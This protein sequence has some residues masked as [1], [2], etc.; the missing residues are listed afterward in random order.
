M[1]R[2]LIGR[3]RLPQSQAGIG[4]LLG[5][6]A[7]G[8]WGLFP[9][10]F[11]V[12]SDVAPIEVVANRVVWSLV[13]LAILTTVTR[14]WARTLLTARERR[15]VVRLGI[16]AMFLAVNWGFYVYAVA[17]NQVVEASLG[18]FINPLVSVG[19]GV[20]VLRERLRTGQW[21]AV[22]IAI[23]AVGVLTVSYGRL[24]WISLILAFS[25][26]IYG[27]IKKQVGTG[28]VESLTIETAVLA[29][30]A[31]VV[32]IVMA[33]SGSSSIT[34]DGAGTVALLVLLGPVTAI[35]LLAFG[36][37]ATRIPLSTLG[38]M[39]Y[40]TPVFQFLLGVFVFGEAMSTT[41]WLGFLLVW[42]SLVV[43]SVDGL[44]NARVNRRPIDD[45]EV[46]EPD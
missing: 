22:G 30:L 45:L 27:L 11:H 4:V 24:P 3:P 2:L 23:L 20:L 15:D 17:T 14:T 8:L 31:V 16:A 35:P 1:D 46:T 41:R 10:Y 13:F 28:A 33:G 34:S 43:M 18:Y 12:L 36:G 21:L 38:L 25:F 40:L 32:M 29:P 7:Y 44:R 19:L 5:F 39:Q 26:G 9:L 37:A 42:I 6:V